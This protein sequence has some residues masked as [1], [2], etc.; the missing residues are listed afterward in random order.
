[1]SREVL[2]FIQAFLPETSLTAEVRRSILR[3]CADTLGLSNVK[4]N[5]TIRSALGRSG[6]PPNKF[7]KKNPHGLR[8]L[9][10]EK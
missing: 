7:L 6:T 2:I 5:L 8:N 9:R 3:H 4:V 1:M 10:G